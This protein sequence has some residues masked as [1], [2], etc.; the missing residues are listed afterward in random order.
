M[1]GNDRSPEKSTD[2]ERN[3]CCFIRKVMLSVVI[4][5]FFAVIL[6][7][8]FH[9]YAQCIRRRQARR[10]TVLQQQSMGEAAAQTHPLQPPK[11]GLYPSL[12]TTLPAFVYKKPA[13]LNGP[14]IECAI[15]LCLLEEEEMAKLL[16]NC[17]HMF[18]EQCINMWLHTSFTCPACRTGAEL[19]AGEGEG[20]QPGVADVLAPPME[21]LLV[22]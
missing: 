15:C 8:V 21:A 20:N 16:P 9:L 3:R 13:E 6:I 11:T 1:S 17:D 19:K 22:V 2:Y 4:T 7:T 5:L 12:I 10:H 14:A 18:H